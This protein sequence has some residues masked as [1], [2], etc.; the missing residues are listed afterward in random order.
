M[1]GNLRVDRITTVDVLRVLSPMWTAKPEVARKTRQ[2]L[3]ATFAWCLAH[4]YLESNPAGEAIDG[5][6]P[7][8]PAVAKHFRAMPYGEV[9][10]ALGTVDASGASIAAKAAFR[11]WC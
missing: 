2:Y 10:A 11:F 1:I 8:M 3:G 7:R 4:G 9:P 5:T 6:L